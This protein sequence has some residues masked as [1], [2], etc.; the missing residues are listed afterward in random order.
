MHLQRQ[1]P[2]QRAGDERQ[3]QRQ[4]DG[5]AHGQAAEA[6]ARDTEGEDREDAA[7][8][9]V[10]DEPQTRRPVKKRGGRAS[11]PSWDEIMFGGGKAD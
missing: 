11:V 3:P 6:G 10:E 5:A 7:V 2:A 9:A 1:Q 4:R 8:A